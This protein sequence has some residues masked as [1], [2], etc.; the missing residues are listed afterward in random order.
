MQTQLPD[1]HWDF[2]D[3]RR[4]VD[5]PA[6]TMDSE[7]FKTFKSFDDDENSWSNTVKNKFHDGV[8]AFQRKF[9]LPVTGELDT[10]T[11]TLM[12]Q[13]RCGVPD[14]A[15]LSNENKEIDEDKDSKIVSTDKEDKV[16]ES[17]EKTNQR[18]VK[19]LVRASKKSMQDFV[20][21]VKS[22]NKKNPSN[23]KDKDVQNTRTTPAESAIKHTTP[24]LTSIL[25][26][27]VLRNRTATNTE[28][29]TEITEVITSVNDNSATVASEGLSNPS[30]SVTQSQKGQLEERRKRRD[31]GS[32]QVPLHRSKRTASFICSTGYT[33]SRPITWRILK[34]N[35][36][37]NQLSD[38]NYF[39]SSSLR[40]TIEQGF[41]RWAE[42][43]RL[44]FKE[45][46]EGSSSSVDIWIQ[47]ITDGTGKYS[48]FV[49]GHY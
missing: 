1:G 41:R 4:E 10:E 40:A 30:Q 49:Q 6:V 16:K 5:N 23:S 38:S 22:N 14:N 47:F 8:R 29:A 19:K 33:T 32:L 15:D 12:E 27:E 31:Q 20:S 44:S 17:D 37:S 35:S 48:Q 28:T 21:E 7:S 18:L 43:S 46:N 36:G 42:V 34:K 11:V 24:T 3:W 39:T 25:R 26:G 13:P 2:V 45:Q 9:N